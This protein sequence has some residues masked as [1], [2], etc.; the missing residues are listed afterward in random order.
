MNTYSGTAFVLLLW[1]GMVGGLMAQEGMSPEDMKR[2]QDYATP[3][4]G[5]LF[6]KKMEG[7]WTAKILMWPAPGA[8]AV[9]STASSEMRL[10]LGGRYLEQT[11]TGSWSGMPFEGRSVMGFDNFSHQMESFWYDSM[12]TGFLHS[13]GTLNPEGTVLRDQAETVDTLSGKKV[14]S[15]SVTTLVGADTIRMEMFWQKEGEEEFKTM[16]IVYGRKK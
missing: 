7:S 2:W 11:H 9:S 12:G 14:R 3:S 13:V 4:E 15:R 6:L 5:H 8:P 16:E 10:I 1:V